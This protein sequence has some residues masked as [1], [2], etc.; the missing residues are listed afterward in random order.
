MKLVWF[1]FLKI[2]SRLPSSTIRLPQGYPPPQGYYPDP[3]KGNFQL[4]NKLRVDNQF[5]PDGI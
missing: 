5:L 1:N 3:H 4:I 2:T